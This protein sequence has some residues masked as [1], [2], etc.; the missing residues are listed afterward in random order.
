MLL[1]RLRIILTA[2]AVSIVLTLQLTFIDSLASHSLLILIN[3]D[4]NGC[5]VR[6]LYQ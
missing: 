4:V 2:T 3:R 5:A 1:F 6:S